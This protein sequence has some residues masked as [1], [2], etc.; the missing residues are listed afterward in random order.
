MGE[1]RCQSEEERDSRSG[2]AKP[3]DTDDADGEQREVAGEGEEDDDD[4]SAEGVGEG[5][6]AEAAVKVDDDSSMRVEDTNTPPA[7]WSTTWQHAPLP[8]SRP[9]APAHVCRVCALAPAHVHAH[10][11]AHGCNKCD[12][13]RESEACGT[14]VCGSLGVGGERARAESSTARSGGGSSREGGRRRMNAGERNERTD[15]PT[16]P[17]RVWGVEV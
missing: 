15:A 7:K 2:E 1:K 8:P 4:E 9:L 6:T 13:G 17:P 11:H 3:A 14:C 10:A 5:C 16:A 12:T